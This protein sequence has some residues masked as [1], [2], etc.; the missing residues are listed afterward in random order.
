MPRHMLAAALM[1]ALVPSTGALLS[2]RPA[3]PAPAGP[4]DPAALVNPLIGSANG[5]NTYPG[6]VL[7]FGMVAWSPESRRPDPQRGEGAMRSAA[8]GGYQ[9][10]TTRIRGFALTHLSGTGCRG[11]SGDVPFLPY[12][13][14]VST[15]PSAD[16]SD[17]TYASDFDHA[18]ERA[19]AGA[20]QVRLASGVNVELGATL[21]T[22]VGRF[23]F[24]TGQ[25]SQPETVLIRTSDSEVGSSDAGTTIDAASH[26]VTG[27]VS[28]GNFCGYLNEIDRRSYYTLYFVAVFDRPFASVGTWRDGEVSPGR[29]TAYGGTT[30]GT[31]GYPAPGK[32]SGAWLD[33]DPAGGQVVTVRVG[34][35]YVSLANARANLNAEDPPGTT[36]D[37]VKARAHGDWNTALGRI[38]VSGGTTDQRAIFYTALYHALLHLNLTSDVNG[39]YRGFDN[40]VH[41]VSGA[42]RAQ[43]ANF[44][45]WDVYRSQLQLVALLDPQTAADMAQSLFNQAR[46]NGGD[47][48]R[49]T[50]NSGATHVM[51]GDPSPSAVAS[52]YAFGGTSFDAHGALASLVRAA[53]VPTAH[54]LSSEGCG[55]ECAGQRPSLDKWL[56]LHYIPA[57]SNAWGGAGETLEDVTA[58]FSLA[59]LA[60][61]LGDEKTRGEFM[62]RA[63]YWKNLF[64]PKPTIVAS[65]GRGG[66]GA[67]SGRG[68]RGGAAG[69]GRSSGQPE[70]TPP[71]PAAAPGPV[72]GYIQNRNE[73]G[74][75][76]PLDPSSSNGFAEGSSAQY[77]W[78]IPFNV[79]G[80][81]DAMGGNEAAVRRLDAFFH[82][83]DGSWAFT[84]AGGLH[85]EM[86][87]EPS[88]ATPWLYLFAG[89]ADRTQQTVRQVITTLWKNA[90][91]GIPGNDDLGAMS[92]WLVWSAMG[93]YPETPGRAE[94]LIGSPLFT[95]IVINRAN[96]RTITIDAPA[97]A[98]DAPYVQSLR[99]NGQASTRAWLPESFVTDGGTL[100]FTLSGTP[101]PT[102]ASRP[103]DAPPSFGAGS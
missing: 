68:G 52:I 5:G 17:A 20:Y 91:D 49:W 39:E 12:V 76:P 103:E 2:A 90:P 28:S 98:A 75:W 44:S 42:Q 15:S 61:R 22:G 70:A 36:F 37:V 32:G 38:Q 7:P 23:S 74:T 30:Y 80:L 89:R 51:E 84:R 27:W 77:T 66:R 64:N 81:F 10:D 50:H 47:W 19:E 25:V 4:H 71:P 53:T 102:W 43:Y 35:S 82:A 63:Q 79:R 40:A 9:R 21:R 78:M 58:D 86:D 45:G 46:Q 1:F 3:Q 26:T 11:A 95:H 94:L 41:H 60:A 54:D 48:D 88:T 87:N 34:I 18:N 72:Q 101:D 93:L 92:A 85:A 33:F 96:G 59:Q 67:R 24:P 97:A 29:T 69:A 13:G 83:A 65:R 73:D 57:K 8:A 16:A 55:I 100:D 56:T 6:A 62:A 14:P 99:L 31:D